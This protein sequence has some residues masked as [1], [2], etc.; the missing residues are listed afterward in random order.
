M[1]TLPRLLV[2]DFGRLCACISFILPTAIHLQHQRPINPPAGVLTADVC[3]P[4]GHRTPCVMSCEF[5]GSFAVPP[6]GAS[7]VLQPASSK[8]PKQLPVAGCLRP[9]QPAPIPRP[10]LLPP[11]SGHPSQGNCAELNFFLGMV[12]GRIVILAGIVMLRLCSLANGV[13]LPSHIAI[14]A[15]KACSGYSELLGLSMLNAPACLGSFLCDSSL[16]LLLHACA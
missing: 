6:L 9:A 15:R 3:R 14:T 12:S 8:H 4:S 1:S 13:K 10:W 2:H 5:D 7:Q 11:A 16:G